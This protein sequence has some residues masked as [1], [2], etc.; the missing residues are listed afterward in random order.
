M[1]DIFFYSAILNALLYIILIGLCMHGW[2]KTEY[3][4]IG[5]NLDTKVSVIVAV[6]NEE[7]V[8]ERCIEALISQTY[9]KE[10]YEVILVNDN[11]TDNSGE[12][13][14]HTCSKYDNV[15]MITIDDN[16]SNFGKKYAISLGVQS[17]IAELIVTTDADCVMGRDWLRTI[18]SSYNQNNSKLI[19]G[20]VALYEEKGILDKLQSLE[21]VALISSGMG[22][23]Y[24]NKALV[25]NGAN[26]AYT[27]KAFNDVN[28]YSGIMDTSSGDDVL[29]YYKIHKKY[30][31]QVSF[32]KSKAAIVCTRG[33]KT[34][35]DLISQRKRWSSKKWSDI[36][37][38]TKFT[39]LVVL[40]FNIQL[41]VLTVWSLFGNPNIN[42]KQMLLLLWLSKL[43]V[44][45]LLLFLTTPFF[46][47]RK[48]LPYFII[49]AIIYPIYMLY[50][51]STNKLGNTT[52]KGRIIS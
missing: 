25:C 48:F 5:S 51:A 49:E 3:T 12:I 21:L 17:S 39:S 7:E 1:I 24:Y 8:I 44:D 50:I 37:D 15:R 32:L 14:Q 33:K 35:N 18:V 26:L 22:A 28:G 40:L 6:R 10:N 11:S 45:F 43:I 34:L 46:G 31:D 41:L 30:P 19:L 23:A 13:I 52:W 38:F 9:A 4:R 29:L 27:R 16:D 36:N 47:K 2:Q 20:P 42:H